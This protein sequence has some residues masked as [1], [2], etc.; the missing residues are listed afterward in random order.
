MDD[1]ELT[2]RIEKL[3][4]E[5]KKMRQIINKLKKQL[6]DYRL[7]RSYSEIEVLNKKYEDL[8]ENPK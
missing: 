3:G 1:R 7:C 5:K 2:L 6:E 4:Q 8:T